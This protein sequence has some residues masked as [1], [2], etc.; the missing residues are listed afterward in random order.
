MT[1]RQG[2]G[3]SSLS[4]GLVAGLMGL[5]MACGDD[6]GELAGPSGRVK[7]QLGETTWQAETARYER[8]SLPAGPS[9][10]DSWVLTA[11][12]AGDTL[13]LT[14]G[15]NRS[16]DTTALVDRYELEAPYTS[17]SLKRESGLRYSATAGTIELDTLRPPP[18]PQ[19]PG[20]AAGSFQLTLTSDSTGDTLRV[21]EGFFSQVPAK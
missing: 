12:R 11:Y 8:L 9:V 4:I 21:R 7:M 10:V 6:D 14:V 2:G 20:A 19:S 1:G 13:Q 3:R 18:A 5:L 17:A 15:K 16:Q